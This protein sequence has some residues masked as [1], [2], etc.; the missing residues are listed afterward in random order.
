MMSTQTTS[1]TVTAAATELPTMA[2]LSLLAKA[3]KENYT[4]IHAMYVHNTT[5]KCY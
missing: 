1:A 5:V 2:P 4:V 3:G